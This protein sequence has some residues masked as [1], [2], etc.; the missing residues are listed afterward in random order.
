MSFFSVLS[1]LRVISLFMYFAMSFFSSLFLQVV[2]SFR[3]LVYF[4]S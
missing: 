3:R 1:M 4:R 2:I